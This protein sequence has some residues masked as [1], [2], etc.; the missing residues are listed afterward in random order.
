MTELK[1]SLAGHLDRP[2]P[3]RYFRPWALS[4]QP[5]RP[6]AECTIDSEAMRARGII[7]VSVKSNQLIKKILRQYILRQLKLDFNLC[8]LPKHC[9]YGRLL[10]GYNMQSSS[11]STNQN[12]SL[13]IDHQLNFTNQHYPLDQQVS[14]VLIPLD[15]DFLPG[16]VIDLG[17]TY[18]IQYRSKV[19]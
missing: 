9:K 7:I 5:M 4:Q 10:V 18:T 17:R 12:A 11:S 15:S 3:S 6:K 1:F 16:I 14:E 2:T 13:I 19:S 8:L